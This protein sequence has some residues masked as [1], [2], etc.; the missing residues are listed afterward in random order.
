MCKVFSY[1]DGRLEAEEF[2]EKLYMEL[3]SSPQPY[4]APFL[5]VRTDLCEFDIKGC[6][7]IENL[8]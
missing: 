2:T 3:K 6:W 8:I 1:Q 4:L 7:R 5:K